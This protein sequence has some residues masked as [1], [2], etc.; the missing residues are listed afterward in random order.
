MSNLSVMPMSDDLAHDAGAVVTPLYSNAVAD[1]GVMQKQLVRELNITE[2]GLTAPWHYSAGLIE[3]E[4]PRVQ[5]QFQDIR[6]ADPGMTD[7]LRSFASMRRERT[8]ELKLLPHSAYR[9]V[10][11]QQNSGA[12]DIQQMADALRLNP[13]VEAIA[14]LT[15]EVAEQFLPEL[16]DQEAVRVDYHAI[17]YHVKGSTV[18]LS[19]P[20]WAHR[21]S[22]PFV[23]LVVIDRKRVVG[24][25]TFVAL[26][27]AR[28][29]NTGL[30]LAEMQGLMIPQSL[31][32]GV[33]PLMSADGSPGWRDA[34]VV[35]VQKLADGGLGRE[36]DNAA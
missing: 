27:G 30:C 34:F 29:P 1:S 7:K 9:Q 35:T 10:V 25:D 16:F 14:H 17:R 3:R 8:G 20:P 18:A 24:G 33:S 19:T 22:E 21:D 5:E 26:G 31:L 11:N 23:H 6:A 36:Y 2:M 15:L 28:L 4:L 32:H 13:L 12:R